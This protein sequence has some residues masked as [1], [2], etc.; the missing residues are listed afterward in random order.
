MIFLTVG[1]QLPFPRLLEMFAAAAPQ[2]VD[3]AFAQTA[4]QD[5]AGPI[6]STPFLQRE[7]FNERYAAARLIIGHA[8]TGTVLAARRHRKP[9]IVVPR[10]FHLGEHRNDHQ[11][12]TAVQ[13]RVLGDTQVCED[14]AQLAE[15]IANPPDPSFERDRPEKDRLLANLKCLIDQAI[16]G[17]VLRVPPQG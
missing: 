16:A 15:A 17:E 11:Y 14:A 8:G 12:A 3:E 4:D 6:A 9:L 10:R 1:T 2:L 5:Y 13:L 7:E